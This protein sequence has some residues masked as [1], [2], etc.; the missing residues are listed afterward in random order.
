MTP[1]SYARQNLA[2]Q[3]KI[4]RGWQHFFSKISL[5]SSRNLYQMGFLK[6][7]DIFQH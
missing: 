6:Q 7:T 4:K 5:V 2:G 1:S 3:C